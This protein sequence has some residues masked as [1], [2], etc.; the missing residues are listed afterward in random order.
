MKAPKPK[1]VLFINYSSDHGKSEETHEVV[2][3][4]IVDNAVS[5]KNSHKNN[6]GDLVLVCES[7]A[8][9][10]ELKNLV[11]EAEESIDMKSPSMKLHSITIVGLQRA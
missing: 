4:V 10:D 8:V 1:A 3:K 6:D 9:R 2:E 11:K 7:Q 5:L